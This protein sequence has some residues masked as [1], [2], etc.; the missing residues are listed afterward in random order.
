M[1]STQSA[2]RRYPPPEVLQETVALKMMNA[3]AGE[4]P[5]AQQSW[6]RSATLGA[7]TRPPL[8][9]AFDSMKNTDQNDRTWA[10]GDT[11]TRSLG[12]ALKRRLSESAAQGHGASGSSLPPSASGLEDDIKG[13]TAYEMAEVNHQCPACSAEELRC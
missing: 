1:C 7:D 6:M 9:S 2:T 11:T 4:E 8:A 10:A 13:A 12:I 5:G 3:C